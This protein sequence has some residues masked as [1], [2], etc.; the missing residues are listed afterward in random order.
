MTR[1]PFGLWRWG[2]LLLLGTVLLA[3]AAGGLLAQQV[4]RDWK[5]ANGVERVQLQGLGLAWSGLTAERLDVLQKRPE[6]TVRAQV[7][8]LALDWNWG[9]PG[10]QLGAVALDELAIDWQPGPET[11]PATNH[12]PE[13]T[14]PGNTSPWIPRHLVINRIIADLPCGTARCTLDG[15]LSLTMEQGE[16]VAHLGETRLKA[17]EP[18]LTL[19]GWKIQGVRADLVFS[20]RVDANSLK[21]AFATPSNLQLANLQLP[22]LQLDGIVHPDATAAPGFDG[23]RADLGRQQLTATYDLGNT[24]LESLAIGGPV[25]ITAQVIRH[26]QLRAQPW[27]FRGNLKGNLERLDL[28]GRLTAKAGAA[29]DLKLGYPY[30]GVLDVEARMQAEGETGGKAL[31]ETLAL[32]PPELTINGGR[33]NGWA[34]L[35]FPP[36]RSGPKTRGE[37]S[38]DGLSGVYDR[39]ALAGLDGTMTFRLEDSTVTAHAPLLKVER[40][41]PGVAIGPITASGHY[42]TSVDRWLEGSLTLEQ[43]SAGFLGG[44][45]RIAP[46]T[47]TLVNTPV[48]IP[49]ELVRV[50]LSQLMRVYPAEGLAGTGQLSGR[51]PVLI[52]PEGI[53]VEQGQVAAVKPGGTLKLPAER[54]RAIAQGNEAMN[55]VARAMENFHYSVL[56]STIDYDQDG[57]LLLG[58]HLEGNNPEVHEGHPIVLNINLEENIPALLTSLQLSGRVNEAVTEKVRELIRKRQAE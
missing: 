35:R 42:Q 18:E 47:W 58:L 54:L 26:S 45:V 36:N 44:D 55:L 37:L 46:A 20:G 30:Q 56:D 7:R 34:K 21:L 43:A 14:S 19:A 1:R 32:W 52:G 29:M 48:R 33:L 49:L 3:L 17:T 23:L 50:E 22:T 41:N 9:W 24:T 10:P 15:K 57:T 40:V 39:T 4:W 11:R 28:V 16:W 8:G 6:R 31:A 12:P 25:A 27:Q 51:V 13:S 38:F 5:Q 53:R 2:V